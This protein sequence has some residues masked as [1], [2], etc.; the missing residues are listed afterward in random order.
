MTTWTSSAKVG[1]GG[2]QSTF[3][4]REQ[5][6]PLELIDALA[7]RVGTFA[8]GRSWTRRLSYSLPR[9]TAERGWLRSV[10]AWE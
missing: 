5:R 8:D 2:A 4:P 7:N 6:G 3:G 9:D 10:I 1:R